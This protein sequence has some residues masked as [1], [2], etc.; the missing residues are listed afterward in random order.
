M[1]QLLLVL[2][3]YKSQRDRRVGPSRVAGAWQNDRASYSHASHISLY[4][5]HPQL[6]SPIEPPLPIH[7][8][9]ELP[10]LLPSYPVK[11]PN[12]RPKMP[13]SVSMSIG[14]GSGPT[15]TRFLYF[16]D[17]YDFIRQDYSASSAAVYLPSSLGSWALGRCHLTKQGSSEAK[18]DG[19]SRPGDAGSHREP[20]PNPSSRL[21]TRCLCGP[22][23]L[24]ICRDESLGV[25]AA[26]M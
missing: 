25:D 9:R 21:G 18:S 13:D 22:R 12:S 11:A 6:R 8:F 19:F 16:A 5:P 17:G 23:R 3:H 1:S 15:N 4:S 24:G 26:V 14:T 20:S 7:S 10:Q 2:E